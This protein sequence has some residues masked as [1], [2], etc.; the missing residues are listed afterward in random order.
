M[1]YFQHFGWWKKT[2]INCKGFRKV[3]CL[4]LEKYIFNVLRVSKNFSTKKLVLYQNLWLIS[5]TVSNLKTSEPGG[6]FY[7]M[8]GS[9]KSW[10]NQFVT[11]KK[12]TT[13]LL[14]QFELPLISMT[15]PSVFY[16][17]SIHL[18]PWP[19]MDHQCKLMQVDESNSPRKSIIKK[20]ILWN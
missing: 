17:W 13:Q 1:L 5:S 20:N 3:E 7:L 15:W 9:D 11:V 6:F 18:R 4:F 19:S 14:L 2:Q 10:K 12:K 8:I 16:R